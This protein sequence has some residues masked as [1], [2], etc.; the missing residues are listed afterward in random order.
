MIMESIP[1]VPCK[2]IM[3][4][5]MERLKLDKSRTVREA[6]ALYLGQALM[7]WTEKQGLTEEIWMQVGTVLIR[8]SVILS[9]MSHQ[10]QGSARKNA[11]RTPYALGFLGERSGRTPPK[12]PK[13]KMAQNIRTGRSGMNFRSIQSSFNSTVSPARGYSERVPPDATTAHTTYIH[14]SFNS[15]GVG[16]AAAGY[17]SMST[18]RGGF[19]VPK[20]CRDQGFASKLSATAAAGTART[21]RIST[22]QPLK[23]TGG[24]GPPCDDLLHEP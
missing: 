24:L 18:D 9:P 6:C 15:V 10:R 5:W 14:A 8:T 3:P 11:E 23:R 19:S 20:Y 12:M 7:S 13:H 16:S 21:D 22:L 4:L 1:E 17:M 2:M